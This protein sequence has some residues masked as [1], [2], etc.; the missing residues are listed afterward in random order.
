MLAPTEELRHL[1]T[2]LQL[3]DAVP[4]AADRV[5]RDRVDV[6]MAAASAASRAGQPGRAAAL[7]VSALALADP[8]RRARLTPAAAFYLIDDGQERG[9]AAAAPRTP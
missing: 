5:G 2:V 1:E 8:V 7:A 6:E 3:W 9:G 4:D